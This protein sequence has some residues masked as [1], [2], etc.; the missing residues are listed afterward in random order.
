MPY[1]FKNRTIEIQAE[2]VSCVT[3]AG[4]YDHEMR[5]L[6]CQHFNAEINPRDV[7]KNHQ[8]AVECKNYCPHGME[9]WAVVYP[10]KHGWEIITE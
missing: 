6:Y 8:K 4:N 9:R 5:P 3:C 10:P 1:K 2:Y 7:L